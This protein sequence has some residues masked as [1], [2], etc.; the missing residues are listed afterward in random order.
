MGDITGRPLHFPN[1]AG[2]ANQPPCSEDSPVLLPAG[3][4]FR[5]VL[6]SI[7]GRRRERKTPYKITGQGLSRG[8]SLG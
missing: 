3:R 7:A 8:P 1:K 4:S 6:F 2:E 5:L